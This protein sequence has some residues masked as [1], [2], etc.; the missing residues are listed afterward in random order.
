MS[1]ARSSGA[2]PVGSP[3]T[4]SAS[5]SDG[6]IEMARFAFSSSAVPFGADV[7]GFEIEGRLSQ[8]F[9]ADVYFTVPGV[10]GLDQDDP[11]FAS[12]ALTIDET[13]G[14]PEIVEGVLAGLALLRQGDGRALYRATVRPRLWQL[15]FVRTSRIFTNRSLREVAVEIF[16]EVG[17]TEGSGFR[18]D[19]ADV[20]VEEHVCQYE[21]SSLDFFHRWAAR[22]GWYYFFDFSEGAGTLVVADHMGAH[23]SLRTS[24]VRY[25][26]GDGRDNSAGEHFFRV[27]QRTAL[28]PAE[29][30]VRDYDYGRPST[31]LS[32]VEAASPSGVGERSIYGV[33]AFDA[34]MVGRIARV[35]AE[36]LKAGANV[37]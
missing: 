9:K 35:Q 8:P 27:R 5:S 15:G 12:A 24:P 11:L 20:P 7:L 4:F 36:A 17:M 30:R 1:R 28:V 3:T 13:G 34:G 37:T 29:V 14:L 21:E 25:H 22:L 18:F 6:D 23:P 16:G 26:P 2:E 31:P 32:K 10:G 33:R 19:I